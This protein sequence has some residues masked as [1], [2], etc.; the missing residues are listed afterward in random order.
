MLSKLNKR[1]VSVEHVHMLGEV[2]FKLYLPVSTD[3]D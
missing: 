2:F 1:P 3:I